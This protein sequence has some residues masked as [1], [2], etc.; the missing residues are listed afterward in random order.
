MKHHPTIKEF[1]LAG[2][3]LELAAEH[4][5]NNSCNDMDPNVWGNFTDEERKQLVKE[6]YVANDQPEEAREGRDDLED[7]CVM[8]HL[9]DK[10]KDFS[11]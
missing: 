11:E 8:S 5:S 2:R 9:A 3:L 7:W 1:Q 4:F 6:Y 10:L